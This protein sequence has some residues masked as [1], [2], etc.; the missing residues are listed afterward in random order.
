MDTNIT[1]IFFRLNIM[2]LTYFLINFC[3]FPFL[4]FPIPVGES[5]FLR[6]KGTKIITKTV[7]NFLFFS[8]LDRIL[9][10]VFEIIF[11]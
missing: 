10:L 3:S 11:K 5:S 2:F 4:L 6:S 8:V 7:H 9:S 1:L